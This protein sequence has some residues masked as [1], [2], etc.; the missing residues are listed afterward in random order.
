MERDTEM[1]YLFVKK[2]LMKVHL[3]MIK[4]LVFANSKEKTDRSTKGTG[5]MG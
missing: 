1:E 3:R 4:F 5:K 2:E